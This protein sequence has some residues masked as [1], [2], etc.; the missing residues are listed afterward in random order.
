MP[1]EALALHWST[2]K[3]VAVAALLAVSAFAGST[4]TAFF[5]LNRFQL[6]RIRER[7]K[8]GYDR[9]RTLLARPSR[10]LVL[11]IL[12]NDVVNIAISS[13]VTEFLEA[14]RTAILTVIP[15]FEAALGPERQ[16]LFTLIASLLVTMPLILLFGEITPKVVAAKMNRLVA[17]LN[18][19][20]LIL[21]YRLTYPVLWVTDAVIS[22]ILRY[23]R[24]E[25]RDYLSKTMSLLSEED[26]MVLMEEGHREGTVNPDER[27]LIQKVFEFDDSTVSEVMTPIAQ[28]FCIPAVAK[29]RDVMPEVRKQKYSRVPVYQKFRGNIV[30]V[31]YMK[32]LLTLRNE[33]HILDLEV[34][35]LMTRHMSVSPNMR[36]SV[37][38]RH[39][40]E[41]KTH[42][43]ICVD[44]ND[45]ALGVVT[46]E[47]VLESIFGEIEDERDLP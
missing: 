30:G 8:S 12:L 16:W 24:T 19:A 5:S 20:P 17:V 7:Y 45:E 2:W 3:A 46:M 26:I 22:F 4:E 25:G 14:N 23:L 9:I 13:L 18:S 35:S 38:F 15:G 31:L 34:K 11:I 33:P 36:L 44:R 40:K 47:D 39:F 1:D 32:D 41:A 10:L 42:M 27:K 6:R 21:L 28:A 43:A 37:L 29:L